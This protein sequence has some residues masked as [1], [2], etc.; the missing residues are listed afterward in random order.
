MKSAARIGPVSGCCC[1][2]ITCVSTPLVRPPHHYCSKRLRRCQ[3][4][5]ERLNSVSPGHQASCLP[6][7]PAGSRDT[8]SGG[9]SGSGSAGPVTYWRE[10]ALQIGRVR[11][12]YTAVHTRTDFFGKLYERARVRAASTA[13]QPARIAHPKMP[14]TGFEPVTHGS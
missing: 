14:K 10:C 6:L 4:P 2:C 1:W 5:M 12:R 7:A 3:Q 8:H 13:S 9:C 11:G